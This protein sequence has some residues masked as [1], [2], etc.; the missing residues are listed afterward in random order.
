MRVLPR[1][2][3]TSEKDRSLRSIPTI[4]KIKTIA[5][6]FNAKITVTES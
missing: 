2:L 6:D 4:A 1:T 3:T 5:I